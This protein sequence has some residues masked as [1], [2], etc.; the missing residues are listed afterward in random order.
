MKEKGKMKSKMAAVHKVLA[1]FIA[2][3]V[4]VQ[5]LL[6]GA[7]HS[8]VAAT[9]DAHIYMGGTLLLAALLALVAAV[10]GRLPRRLI[11]RTA[12]LFA[13]LLLQPLLIKQRH[14]GIPML[15]ALHP[16]NGALVALVA[17]TLAAAARRASAGEPV[18]GRALQLAAG[19]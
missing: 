19:D 12:L 15:S 13:L 14:A 10:T 11:A 9:P 17:W 18:R 8:R 16:M 5:F 1:I 6:A 7:W 4:F 2:A 3:G